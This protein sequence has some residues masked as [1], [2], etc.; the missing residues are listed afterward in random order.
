MIICILTLEIEIEK[1]RMKRTNQTSLFCIQMHK[2]QVNI[3]GKSLF[4]DGA[5]SSYYSDLYPKSRWG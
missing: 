4:P 5:Y 1:P 3:K 2:A